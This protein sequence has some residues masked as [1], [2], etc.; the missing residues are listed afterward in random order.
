MSDI[1][2]KTSGLGSTG[3]KKASSIFVKT[4]GLG[5][6]GWRSA[7]GVWIRNAT[8]WLKVWPLSGIFATRV[9]YIAKFSSNTYAE[10]MPNATYPV[11][12]IGDSYFGDNAQWDLNGWLA[13]SYTYRWKIYAEYDLEGSILESGTGSGWTS[14]AGEDQLPTSIWTVTNSTNA[15]R[16][17]LGFEVI[18][19]NSSNSQY[20]GVSVSTKIQ[21]VRQRPRIATAPSFNITSPKIGDTINYSSGWDI[22]E[23]YRPEPLRSTIF[24]YKNSTATTTGGTQV[25]S[26][27]Y[28]YLVQAGDLN[29]YIYAVETNFN[30]GSDYDLGPSIG[31][32][33]TAIT[34][35]AVITS[36]LPA[37]TSL[38][39]S[40]NRGDGVL[41][42][43]SAVT[44]ANYYEI[45]WQSSQGT[46]PVNQSLFSDFGSDNSITGTSFIDT[47][48]SPGSTRYYRV[49]ARSAAVSTGTNCSNWFPAPASNAIAGFRIKPGA[50]TRPTSYSFATST[51]TGYFTTGTNT[52]SVQYKL[53][54]VN[55][56]ISTPTYTL[57][58]TSSYPYQVSLN[59]SSLFTERT[60]TNDTWSPSTTY[61]A[62][63][64]VWYAGNQYQSKLIS[65]SGAGTVPSTSGS[66][67][68]WTRGSLVG[69]TPTTSRTWSSSTS[70]TQ[71]QTVYYGTGTTGASV[72]QYTAND[73]GFSGQS[74]TNTTYWTL[75]T[76]RTYYVGDYVI[77]N[78]TR[79]YALQTTTGVYP[80]SGSNWTG[81]L[82]YWRYEFTPYFST[83]AGDVAYS[84]ATRDMGLSHT[85]PTD[86]LVL[87]TPITFS[88]VT[89]TSFT[90]N[91]TTGNYANYTHIDTYKISP[92]NRPSN[93]P[94]IIATLNI[95]TYT[96]TPTGPLE[97][98]TD[99]AVNV[100]PR[101][102]YS[103]ENISLEIPN[104][105]YEGTTT[106][107]TIKTL[108]AAPTAPTITSVTS[109]VVYSPV[110]VTC[111]GGSGPFYQMF[112]WGSATAPTGAQTPDATGAS[113]TPTSTP[114]TLTDASGPSINGTYWAFVR[115]VITRDDTSI[116]PSN[117]V[118]A[119]SSAFQFTVTL[120][121]AVP[122]SY[123]TGSSTSGGWSATISGTS[124]SGAT[125]SIPATTGYSV[126]SS[127]G[128]V[129]ATGLGSNVST[130]IV[131][132][133]SVSGY[134]NTTATASGT[135]STIPTYSLFYS[136]NSGSFTPTTQ[137]GVQG[138]SIT[139]AANAGTRAGFTFGGWSIGGIT[140]SGSGSYTFGAG[141][142]TATAI[143]NTTFVTPTC[144][145]PS[146]FFRR[147]PTDTSS[148]WEYFCD[149]PT[150]SG[151]YQSI[152]GMQ[153][154][155]YS[156]NSTA[157]SK[158]TGGAGIQTFPGSVTTYPYT[159]SRD[160]TIWGFRIAS[161]SSSSSSPLGTRVATTARRYGRVR[162]VMLGTNGTTYYGTWTSPLL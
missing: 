28:S 14:T 135:S 104:I 54:G 117:T 141:N 101:Y 37:P 51:A 41:L 148:S 115:S 94:K 78:G 100:T 68:Y 116:G 20:N 32:S 88:N 65:F 36:L 118:S 66:N 9:P 133:K 30:S 120:N 122:F 99:Y 82:G 156:A 10:R 22:T 61:Y 11:V 46:G 93:Y 35:N 19:N 73:P 89:S 129:T 8:Q 113:N 25:Q 12:R 71:G 75:I 137:T 143:W 53:Q 92:F 131:V 62:N 60:W 161:G 15:D 24:W 110:S 55:I 157:G 150:P 125:Y 134:N 3:W 16:K 109:G 154:E 77:Y 23:A 5:S 155:I 69:T 119:W 63:N 67:T 95:Q 126:N 1:F 84:S 158:V 59:P 140:Y 70:Y 123:N 49:R 87:A 50:I 96:D 114:V 127:T 79:F 146:L 26:G 144:P 44:G 38:T 145:A 128:T 153:F 138:A 83:A 105:Y 52:S 7:V 74:P 97:A 112:W 132:T 17:F 149:Y 162:V 76:Q 142:A 43:W 86:S 152:T 4:S 121:P 6:T 81:S 48:I 91:Y 111:N 18:A 64:T 58:T 40:S 45:Y 98:F 85:A 29:H 108:A 57:S 31:V 130:S 159:S 2:V 151:S 56:P 124:Q 33:A 103:V 21:I 136:A 27:G 80:S 107:G 13:S 34:N 39:A 42:S 47:T 72:Y 147:F 160:G 90:S 139:L 106:N 102:Y